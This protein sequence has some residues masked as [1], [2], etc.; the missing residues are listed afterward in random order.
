[1]WLDKR[2]RSKKKKCQLERRLFEDD[3]EKFAKYSLSSHLSIS[4][5]KII[6]PLK[7]CHVSHPHYITSPTENRTPHHH[8]I[9]IEPVRMG[10][11]LGG[12]TLVILF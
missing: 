9:P 3:K 4:Q 6:F 10:D 1:M 11:L 2:R 7:S 12:F 5:Q 8:I